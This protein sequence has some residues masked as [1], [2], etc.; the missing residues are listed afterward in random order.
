M[1][2]LTSDLL[3]LKSLNA[4]RRVAILTFILEENKISS[5]YHG[6]YM[7]YL[8]TYEYICIFF[9]LVRKS[10]ATDKKFTPLLQI[11]NL[12]GDMRNFR[13]NY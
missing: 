3:E 5:L 4:Q 13:Y 6:K 12:F 8:Y 2:D 1:T 10:D 9:M 11:F 7:N